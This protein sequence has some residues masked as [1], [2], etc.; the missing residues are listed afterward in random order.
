MQMTYWHTHRARSGPISSYRPLLRTRIVGKSKTQASVASPPKSASK[1]RGKSSP[2]AASP[3]Q[4]DSGKRA[5]FW[6]WKAT[7]D[8]AATVYGYVRADRMLWGSP[9]VLHS[10]Q[11]REKVDLLE[12]T[13]QRAAQVLDTFS[14]ISIP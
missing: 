3:P 6:V 1:T 7:K 12:D 5:E 8:I 13:A 2:G 4:Q 11:A 10:S 9:L 14:T